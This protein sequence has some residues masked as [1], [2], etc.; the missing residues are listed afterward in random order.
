[1]SRKAANALGFLLFFLSPWVI[2]IL[3]SGN[4]SSDKPVVVITEKAVSV[5]VTVEAD[6][7]DFL[8]VLNNLKSE[9]FVYE[10]QLLEGKVPG[11]YYLVGEVEE[12]KIPSLEKIHGVARV[13]KNSEVKPSDN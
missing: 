4:K 12:S 8:D 2:L 6:E 10:K 11:K 9:G 5:I 3:L 1:M 13:S 7:K